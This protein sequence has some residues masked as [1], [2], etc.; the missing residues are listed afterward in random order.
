M[1]I[2]EFLE[3]VKKTYNSYFPNSRCVAKLSTNLGSAVFIDCFIANSLEEEPNKI[4]GND[5]FHIGFVIHMDRETLDDEFETHTIQTTSNY[6]AV[7]SS[8]RYLAFDAVKIPFRK[9]TGDAKKII[10]AF[11]RFVDKLYTI[12]KQQY[13]SGNLTDYWTKIVEDGNKL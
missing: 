9:T 2:R 1:M 13:E 4:T 5:M 11:D 3:E 10:S 8:N 12:T 6:I 7:K